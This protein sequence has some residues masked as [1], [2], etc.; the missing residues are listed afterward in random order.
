MACVDLTYISNEECIGNSLSS[1]NGNFAALS[2]AVCDLSGGPSPSDLLTLINTLSTNMQNIGNYPYLEYAWVTAPNT[3]AQSISNDGTFKTLTLNTELDD[4]DNYGSL[5]AVTSRI[6]LAGGT[7]RFQMS[8]PYRTP[9][10]TNITAISMIFNVTDNLPIR[11]NSSGVQNIGMENCLVL[12]GQFTITSQKVLELRVLNNSQ[13]SLDLLIK[14]GTQYANPTNS[15]AG[16]DQRTTIKLW[17]V[18]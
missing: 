11:S 8:A 13:N 5:D 18:G 10:N 3:A 17:K 7:Y 12:E 15:S 16:Y 4:N 2:S 14:S 6:T 1:I 9:N